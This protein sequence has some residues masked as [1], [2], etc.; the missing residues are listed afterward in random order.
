MG[1]MVNPGWTGTHSADFD[2]DAIRCWYNG[3]RLLCSAQRTTKPFDIA[4]YFRGRKPGAYR[5]PNIP[6]PK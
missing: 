4:R 6:S 1:L 3:H 5:D 2:R